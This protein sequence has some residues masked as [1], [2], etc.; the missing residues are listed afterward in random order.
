M[1]SIYYRV[2]HNKK[3]IHFDNAFLAKMKSTLFYELSSKNESIIYEKVL[4]IFNSLFNDFQNKSKDKLY[5]IYSLTEEYKKLKNIQIENYD[6]IATNVCK[7]I[8]EKDFKMT[9]NFNTENIN[10]ICTLMSLGF[11]KLFSSNSKKY[12]TYDSFLVE[13]QSY[14]ELFI[15]FVRIYQSY[16]YS[17]PTIVPEI[18][19]NT[20]PNELLLLMEIFQ[21]IKHINLSLKDY[22]KDNIIF[23]LIILLNYDWL[24]PFVFEIDLDLSFEQLSEEIQNIYYIK[25]KNVYIKN[26][27]NNFGCN[28]FEDNNNEDIELNNIVNINLITKDLNFYNN[29]KINWKLVEKEK[30]LRKRYNIFSN[31]NTNNNNP[32]YINL[33]IRKDEIEENYKKI[34]N[35]NKDIFDIILCYYYLIKQVKYLKTLSINMP[36]GFIKESMDTIRMK[37]IPDVKT[38][39]IFEY[40]TII[41]NLCS[42]NIVF[43]SLEKRTFENIIYIIQN[44]SNLKELKIDFFPLNCKNYTS[45]NLIKLAEECAICHKIISSLNKDYEDNAFLTLTYDNEK[46]IKQKLLEK[47]ELNLEKLFLLFQTKKLLEKIELIFDLPL[48]LCNEEG[49]HWTIL[50]FIFNI[51]ILLQKETFN[52]KE[53]NLILP[54]FNLDN[55]QYPV[56]GDFLEKINLNEKNKLIK[57]FSLKANIFKLYNIKNLISYNL[58]SLNI[59]ELDLDTFKAFVD[60]YQTKEFLEKSKLQLLSIELNKTVVKYSNCKTYLSDF[61]SG[62]NPK[63]LLELS[64]KFYFRIK[65]KQLYDLLIKGNGNNIERY[66]FNMRVENYKKYKKIV[67][68]NAFYYLNNDHKKEINKYIPVLKKYNLIDNNKKNITNRILVFLL[69][70]NK[71]KISITNIS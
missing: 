12:K 34:L 58:I 44:N 20:I 53:F 23:Y 69:P 49:Y 54:F 43:N 7:K 52:L 59:G 38:S 2:N 11:T 62:Q 68:H 19:K 46:V 40:L 64:F 39:N 67:N 61:I 13:M 50:K 22:N 35:K 42:F 9:L 14:R 15:D 45:Q 17:L 25:E 41:S 60:F 1:D 29:K 6:K 10:D 57:N 21:G 70:S 48:I 24:F 51:I 27:K 3:L 5:L 37:N 8:I 71:K 36:N 66:N 28:E 32:D 63:Y 30:K 16:N 56:I 4:K 65:S 47:F 55:R 31:N 26:R 33:I 18:Q